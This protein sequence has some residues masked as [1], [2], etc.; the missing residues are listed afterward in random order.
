L[1]VSNV[2]RRL[3][4]AREAA[5]AR[6]A[7]RRDDAAGA[8]KAY[9]AFLETVAT[10]VVRQVANALKVE[11][12]NFTVFTPQNGLRLAADR[13]RDDFIE[14]SLDR[15]GLTP[16][17]VARVSCARGSRTL[18]ETQAIKPGARPDEVT[19]EDVLEFLLRA[20]EPW[21]ER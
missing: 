18:D 7:V 12:L 5:K 19:E 20:L 15:T 8:E 16:E 1:E 4:I 21:L 6:A 11:G 3:K 2:S 10:P 14:V 13:G 17:V 9:A